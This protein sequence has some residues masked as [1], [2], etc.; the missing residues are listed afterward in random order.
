MDSKKTFDAVAESRKWRIAT[1]KELSEMTQ[2]ER[3]SYLNDRIDAKLE[4]LTGEPNK[5]V[6]SSHKPKRTVLA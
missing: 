4:A 2:D 1:G 6:K 3:L 5:A